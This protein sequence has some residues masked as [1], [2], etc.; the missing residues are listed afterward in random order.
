M[1]GLTITFGLGLVIGGCAS[2]YVDFVPSPDLGTM[3]TDIVGN[4]QGSDGTVLRLTRS[5]RFD[6]VIPKKDAKTGQ[7]YTV[8]RLGKWDMKGKTISLAGE[9]QTAT[10]TS[11]DLENHLP[12]NP[13][14][15]APESGALQ[16]KNRVEFS[17][18]YEN[19]NHL[20]N[21]S[22]ISRI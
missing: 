17:I 4:W 16:W 15:K 9:S 12:N 6:E 21:Y 3:T 1:R 5:G 18:S 14:P 22:R 19:P 13:P 8:T 7:S 11:P 10:T 20:V 2:P